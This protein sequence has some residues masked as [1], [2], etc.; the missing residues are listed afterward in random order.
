MNGRCSKAYPKDFLEE[1]LVHGR[2]GRPCYR[3]RPNGPVVLHNNVLYDTRNVVPHCPFLLMLFK[4][5]INV[6]AI[7]CLRSLR[8]IFKY[9][10]KGNDACIVEQIRV[11][12]EEVEAQAAGQQDDRGK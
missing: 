2:F 11:L 5:H 3:R 4:T 1:T 6:E 7:T 9:V 10:H 8:Y 12:M